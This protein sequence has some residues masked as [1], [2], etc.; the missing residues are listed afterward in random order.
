M[1]IKCGSSVTVFVRQTISLLLIVWISSSIFW[2]L[3]NPW[4]VETSEFSKKQIFESGNE[5]ELVKLNTN[6]LPFILAALKFCN[7]S[8][9][10]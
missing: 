3:M 2:I 6:V 7:P 4:S 10:E 1:H 9:V 8:K 5:R